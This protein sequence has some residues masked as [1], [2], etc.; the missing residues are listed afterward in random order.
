MQSQ[1]FDGMQG[2]W[3]SSNPAVM[4]VNQQGQALSYGPGT[5]T[6]SFKSA[7][8][9]PFSPWVMTVYAAESFF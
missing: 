4:Y 3:S 6:I 1:N 5:A 8:G 2:I 9:V 7:S